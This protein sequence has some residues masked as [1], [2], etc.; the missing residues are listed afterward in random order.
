MSVRLQEYEPPRRT[1]YHGRKAFERTFKVSCPEGTEELESPDEACDLICDLV[2]EQ[3]W[4]WWNDP[5][6]QR[7]FKPRVKVYEVLR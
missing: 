3:F 7:R 2:A 5:T 4:D 6:R 1:S